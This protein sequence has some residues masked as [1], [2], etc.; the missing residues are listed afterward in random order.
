MEG[1]AGFGLTPGERT[2]RK[3]Q[4]SEEIAG[5]AGGMREGVLDRASKYGQRGGVVSGAMENID[6]SKIMA[7]VEG[8][9]NISA[10]NDAAAQQKVANA[11]NFVTWAPPTSQ[12]TESLGMSKSA[13][14]GIM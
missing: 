12:R 3:T 1:L 14:F 7:F 9:R 2:K 11:L 8:L 13:P 5:Y 4:L 6:A 10:A